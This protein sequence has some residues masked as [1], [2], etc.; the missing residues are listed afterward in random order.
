MYF[1]CVCMY[2]MTTYMCPATEV[3]LGEYN[4]TKV[5]MKSMKDVSDS[6]GLMQF[7]TE[8]SVMT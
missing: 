1:Y 8:A 3:C 7:L 4:G 6:K 5:A 2:P